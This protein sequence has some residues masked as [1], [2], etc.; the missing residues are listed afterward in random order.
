MIEQLTQIRTSI[1]SPIITKVRDAFSRSLCGEGRLPE[2]ILSMDGMSGRKYRLFINNLVRETEDA[3]Y[4]EVGVWAGSTLCSAINGNIVRAIAIHN[5]SEFGGP[6]NMF[7]ENLEKFRTPQANVEFIEKDF[8]RVDFSSLGKFNIYLF[9]GPHAE[10]DQYDGIVQAREAFSDEFVLIVDDWNWDQVR[11]GTFSA[12]TELKASLMFA[13]EIRT[14][15]DNVHAHPSGPHSD[16]H[17]GYFIA[18]LAQ[19]ARRS[20]KSM[21]QYFKVARTYLWPNHRLAVA[22]E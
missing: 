20:G 14:S 22:K 18:V 6:K 13:L 10:Q 3:H 5:W 2:E 11:K 9:D 17:N 21:K 15:F 8:R 4:L 12:I 7:I 16:W 1:R 19:E